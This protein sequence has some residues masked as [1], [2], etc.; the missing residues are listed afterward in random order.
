MG[1]KYSPK[2]KPTASFACTVLDSQY[3]NFGRPVPYGKQFVVATGFLTNVIVATGDSK[4]RKVKQFIVKVDNVVF[5]P[6]GS[7]TATALLNDL[8]SESLFPKKN[9][10]I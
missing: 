8:D 5:G 2:T 1:P 3:E 4:L 10:S 9:A 7:A 6:T